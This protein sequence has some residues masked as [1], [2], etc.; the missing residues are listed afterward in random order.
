MRSIKAV[1][2]KIAQLKQLIMNEENPP[3]VNHNVNVKSGWTDDR[4]AK[5]R[6]GQGIK[7]NIRKL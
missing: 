5:G 1:V 2:L 6:W 4:Q 3:G 7:E